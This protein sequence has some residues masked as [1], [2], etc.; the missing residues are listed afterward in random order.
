MEVCKT[1]PFRKIR[2]K[3]VHG[4]TRD[5]KRHTNLKFDVSNSREGLPD[6]GRSETSL[7]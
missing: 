5:L 2:L 1:K 7:R 4:G 3:E 6:E